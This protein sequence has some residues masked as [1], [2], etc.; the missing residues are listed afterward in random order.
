MPNVSAN[1]TAVNLN[2]T[3]K[4]DFIVAHAHCFAKLVTHDPSRLVLHVQIAS[5][6]QG[7]NAFRGIYEKNNLRENVSEAQF[8]A[9]ED[10]AASDTELLMAT[11]ALP[12]AAGGDEIRLNTATCRATQAATLL[13][14][15]L[16]RANRTYAQLS[17]KLA[18]IG[19]DEKEANT[20]N[21]LARGK[22]SAAFLIQCLT[23]VGQKELRF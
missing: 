16:K 7:A 22:F 20:R 13:K 15:E 1:V 11:A 10:R 4:H 23:A 6:L 14:A 2:V 18:E 17:G 8:A 19:V 3:R 12:L 21:K 9:G 5:H